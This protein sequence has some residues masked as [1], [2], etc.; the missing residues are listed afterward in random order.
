MPGAR[1]SIIAPLLLALALGLG[2]CC[3]PNGPAPERVILLPQDPAPL[4]P[5][6]GQ[7]GCLVKPGWQKEQAAKYLRQYFDPWLRDAPRHSREEL[8]HMGH[9]AWEEPGVGANLRPRAPGWAHALLE[10]SGAASYPSTDWQGLTLAACDLRV[11]PT[12]QPDYGPGPGGGY[13]FDR[14]Q[15]TALPAGMPVRVW[16]VSPR[17]DWLVAETPLALGWLPAGMVGRLSRAQ[18]TVWRG[19]E[20]LAVTRDRAALRGPGG[21]FVMEASLGWLLPL[22]GGSPGAWRVL[23]P[24]ARADGSADLALATLPRAAGAAFPLVLSPGHLVELAGPLMGRA[25]GWGGLGGERDCS[26]LT[27][28]LLAPFGLWLPRNSAD[29]GK[30]GTVIDLSGLDDAAKLK[31]IRGQGVPWLSLLYMPGH[32]MLY[33]GSRDGQPR[34]L[35]AM[36]G[37]KTRSAQGEGRALV[38]RVVITGLNPGA[39]L[40]NLARP[41][42]LLLP[43]ISALA[44]LAPPEARCP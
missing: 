28:E 27:R 21:R 10:R 40:P 39:H 36:W 43:R 42:G 44:I 18:A 4:A 24:R 9:H 7:Q 25:Y 29:Q 33:L 14:L 2:A 16:H 1:R 19:G 11:L 26:S 31:A 35:H 15:Q 13:P 6:A 23:I 12:R 8:L 32:V 38:G 17:G 22:R 37:L 3:A 5:R 41:E 30:T 34:V 20:F